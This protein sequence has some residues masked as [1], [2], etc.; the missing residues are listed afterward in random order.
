MVLDSMAEGFVENDWLGQGLAIGSEASLEVAMLDPR[1]VMTTQ[2]Q[3]DLPQDIEI[4]RTLVGH[5]SQ[6]VVGEAR[7]PCAGVYAVIAKAGTIR[8]GDAVTLD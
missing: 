7:F 8:L 5:N 3:G 1:C 2:P 6:A 4:I